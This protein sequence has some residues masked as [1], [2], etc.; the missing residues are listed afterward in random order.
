MTELEII[1]EKYYYKDFDPT[2]ENLKKVMD[3]IENYEKYG[4]QQ[5]MYALQ[6]NHINI[7]EIDR[8]SQYIVEARQRL[9]QELKR[10]KK[11]EKTHNQEFATDHNGYY[12]AVADMLSKIRSHMSA[13]K[14][15]LHK[16]CP[17]NHPNKNIR[18]K[19]NIPSKSIFDK[20]MLAITEYQEDAFGLP[21]YPD[22]V[23]G[24]HTELLKF[25]EAQNECFTICDNIIKEEEA[26]RKD[27]LRAKYIL[28]IYRRKAYPKLK[29]T[30][31]LISEEVIEALK[32]ITPS[33]LSYQQASSEEVFA[34]NEFHEHNVI[35]MDHFCLIE[36]LEKD[37]EFTNEE[38]ALFGKAPER[39]RNIK[40]AIMN[41]DNC[42]PDDFN[43]KEL[44]EY[45]YMFCKWAMPGNI[46]AMND[47][48]M[49]HYCGKYQLTKYKGV[50]KH[51][52][53]YN[54]DSEKVIKFQSRIKA[55]CNF[56]QDITT[57]EVAVK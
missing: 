56:G 45:Q 22:E 10:V 55:C 33:Y 6:M 31:M 34:A 32:T 12:N 21:S 27:P 39:I 15:I 51:G 54:K 3:I 53:K 24:L 5:L 11:Y 28:D 47:Y 14:T 23:N 13:L 35:D 19:Y 7:E 48:L 9:E 52:K 57:I 50:N 44:G 29:S 2:L 42:L 41:F 18:K 8:L 16:T 4:A 43:K 38:Y 1:K 37:K 36:L 46:S 49:K 26:I 30:V 25:F 40:A 20:S 17:R